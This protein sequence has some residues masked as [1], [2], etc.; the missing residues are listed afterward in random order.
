MIVHILLLLII[1]YGCTLKAS[2]QKQYI[3]TLGL[4]LFIIIGFRD[5]SVGSDT[6]VYVIEYLN[7]KTEYEGVQEEFEP[8]RRLLWNFFRSIG[9][10]GRGFLISTAFITCVPLI[11]LVRR[12]SVWPSYSLLLYV[13]IGNYAFNLTGIRQ[14]IA[15]SVVY[16]GVYFA[17]RLR[18]KFIQ[19]VIIVLFV[20]LASTIHTSANVCYLFVV[21]LLLNKIKQLWI[22][23]LLIIPWMI[24]ALGAVFKQQLAAFNSISKYDDYFEDKVD[25]NFIF[26]FLIPYCIFAF[27]SF[28]CMKMIKSDN[29][30]LKS[31]INIS[32]CYYSTFICSVVGGICMS[33]PMLNRLSL[34]F[35]LFSWILISYYLVANKLNTGKNRFIAIWMAILCIIFFLMATPN[36]TLKIGNYMFSL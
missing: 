18:R 24:Y 29:I 13:T 34:Y 16:I 25:P 1:A 30:R 32:F 4:L 12:Y 36:G 35:N 15:C 8:G 3:I 19:M 9:L 7:G 31:P 6:F 5:V 27:V 22:Y 28:F 26:Y 17:F 2:I 33:L 14:S 10:G 20:Y 11:M 21:F 23:I